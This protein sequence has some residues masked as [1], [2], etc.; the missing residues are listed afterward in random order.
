VARLRAVLVRAGNQVSRRGLRD[1][2][3]LERRLAELARQ[4]EV[5]TPEVK[6]LQ[7][8][9]RA[10]VDDTLTSILEGMTT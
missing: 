7:A 2:E 3:G 1:I 8:Y 6:D 10:E 4:V 5:S 9:A